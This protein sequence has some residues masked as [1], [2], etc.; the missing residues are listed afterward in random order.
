MSVLF[1]KEIGASGALATV[2]SPVYNARLTAR[3]VWS[4]PLFEK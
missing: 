3:V 1:G 2:T 4:R